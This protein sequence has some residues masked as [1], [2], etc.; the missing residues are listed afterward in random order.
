[1]TAEEPC[2]C[3]LVEPHT[4]SWKCQ[5]PFRYG[6]AGEALSADE[7]NNMRHS[8]GF[9]SEHMPRMWEAHDYWRSRAEAAE[10]ENKRLRE[11]YEK[12]CPMCGWKAVDHIDDGCPYGPAGPSP[13]VRG[14]H[15]KNIKEARAALQSVKQ[16][17]ACT[18]KGYPILAKEKTNKNPWC[19][20]HGEPDKDEKV[21]AGPYRDPTGA[22]VIGRNSQGGPLLAPSTP[23]LAKRQCKVPCPCI[24]HVC[25]TC[26][27]P[28]PCGDHCPHTTVERTGL[29][30]LRCGR[31]V[32]P[33]EERC[34]NC[35]QVLHYHGAADAWVHGIHPNDEMTCPTRSGW[36]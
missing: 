10:A 19:S 27:E 30:C 36:K 24:C 18:C 11:K 25:A 8:I 32:V 16:A 35:H 22:V 31:S 17:P 6:K 26:G 34:P 5:G 20:V 2:F 13:S 29:Y 3:G 14:K 33:K 4:K 21:Q 15:Y 12:P 7:E 28:E 1:V 9:E 23:V